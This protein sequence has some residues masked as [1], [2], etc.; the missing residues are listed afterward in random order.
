MKNKNLNKVT[1]SHRIDGLFRRG[2]GK[3]QRFILK[4]MGWS[5]IPNV[6]QFQFVSQEWDERWAELGLKIRKKGIMKTERGKN[7]K[8]NK[9]MNYQIRRMEKLIS[10]PER[11]YGIVWKLMRKS[12]AFRLSAWNRVC[13]DWFYDLK[14]SRVRYVNNRINKIIDKWDTNLTHRR[15]YIP[16]GDSFRPLGIPTLEWRIMLHMFNNFN[17]QFTRHFFLPSQHG[18]IKKKGTLTA[19]REVMKKVI[20]SKYVYECDLKQFFPS[21]KHEMIVLYMMMLRIPERVIRWVDNLNCSIPILPKI[22][23]LD[24]SLMEKKKEINSIYRN[25]DE[26]G[27]YYHRMGIN[28]G[29]PQ[30]SPLSPLLSMLG[31][32][33]FLFQQPSVSYADDPIFYKNKGFSIYDDTDQ[34]LTIN[35]SKSGWVKRNGKWVNSLTFLGLTYDPWKNTLANKKGPLTIDM[36]TV[37]RICKLFKIRGYEDDEKSTKN[38]SLVL[39]NKKVSGILMNKLYANKWGNEIYEVEKRTVKKNSWMYIKQRYGTPQS[40]L[41]TLASRDFSAI[42]DRK[43]IYNWEYL[44]K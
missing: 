37:I 8:M 43:G 33:I 18:F 7:H 9:Y 41:S 3:S 26:E 24:E 15:V 32:R 42:I 36:K 23:L 14:I 4:E 11:Y 44:N 40:L 21:V 10:E 2:V 35:H 1:L 39:N 29:V 30:G 22:K 12:D 31:M 27:N 34:G 6:S 20:N 28:F 19:W 5:L 25:R 16:K 38:W 13:K 17:F